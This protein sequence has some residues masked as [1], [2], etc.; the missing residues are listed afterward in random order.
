MVRECV[1][2]EII[3]GTKQ[4][5]VILT[6]DSFI[7]MRDAN[8]QLPGHLLVIPKKHYVTLLD[9]PIRLGSE[10]LGFLQRVGNQL[11]ET[12]QGNGFNIIMNNLE[13]AGQKVLHAHLHVIPRN[14]GD[15]LRFLTKV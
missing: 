14:E 10:L 12:K 3:Q 2:C 4:G 6:S 13:P 8:P 5:D 15:G 11:L 7:A 1:F 9:L